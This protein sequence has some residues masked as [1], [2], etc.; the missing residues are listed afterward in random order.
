MHGAHQVEHFLALVVGDLVVGVPFG[1][2]F[3]F[4]HFLGGTDDDGDEQVQHHE[5]GNQNERH[6]EDPGHGIDGHHRPG[7]AHGPAFQ[8]HDL[9]QAVNARSQSAEPLRERLTKQLGAHYRKDVEHHQ[10]QRCGP[11]DAG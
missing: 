4:M 8:G 3:A 11:A 10:Q 5:A 6:E 1:A 2:L 9:E 7:N